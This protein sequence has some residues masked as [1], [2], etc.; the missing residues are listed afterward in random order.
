[1][2]RRIVIAALAGTW[3]AAGFGVAAGGQPDAAPVDATAEEAVPADVT[4]VLDKMDAAGKELKAVRA[5]F[6]Y[7]LNQTLYEDVQKRQGELVYQTPNLL[8]FEFVDKPRE[9][10][11]FD[12]RIV[13]HRKD[14]TR[15][16][17]LWELR[18]PTEPPV[19]S[20]ELGK[21]PFPQPFGQ[22]KAVVLKH[23]RVSRDAK[24]E[25]SDAKK[26]I[27][28]SLVPR[29]DTDLAKDYTRIVL[30]I[31][32]KGHMPSRA[33]LYDTSENITT[34]DFHHMEINPTV[35]A[36]LFTRPKVP[37][38]WEIVT[39]AKEDRQRNATAP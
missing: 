25:K 21:T 12:G 23:F 36:A 8:R 2:N 38:D 39:H 19:D 18:L 22:R 7:E 30:W 9:T 4:D 35:D 20:F 14:S 28:L 17:I 26:R 27:V 24:E 3:L 11:V 29:K 33:R 34:I 1:M 15:Q 6:D 13:Y 32:P 16:L 5:K 10:L 37:G 31:E